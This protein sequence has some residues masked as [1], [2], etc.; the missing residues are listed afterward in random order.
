MFS[1]SDKRRTALR[2]SLLLIALV[3]SGCGGSEQH[4]EI[5]YGVVRD[6]VPTR[7]VVVQDD[8]KKARR[9]TGAKRGASPVLPKWSPDGNR[10]A[11][12]RFRRQG[13]PRSLQVYVVNGDG[14]NE[15]HV[16]EGTLPSWTADGRFL[17]VERLRLA[18]QVST[19]HVLAASG[20]GERKLTSGSS[21]VLSHDGKTVAFVRYTYAKQRGG[22][23]YRITAT[24]LYTIA[25]DGTKL[26]L[27]SKAEGKELT[28]PSWLPG[29][30]AIAVLERRGGGGLGGPL[31]RFSLNGKRR[32]VARGVGETYAWSPKGDLLAYTA[33]G[34]L[35]LI[36]PDG[37][38]VDAFGQSNAIDIEWSPDGTKV[39]FSMQEA[40]ET[41]QFVGFYIIDIEKGERRRFA[42]ADGFAAF[43]DWRPLRD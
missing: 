34:I 7:I 31:W 38:E 6:E 24:R 27:I 26:R 33:G 11:F 18:P 15:R 41:A 30:A 20:N 16:G 5:A 39:A 36:R 42:L 2:H 12:V 9:V 35:Y 21:P 28:Q 25:L 19:I 43:L 3:L 8:G 14:S 4:E 13:G 40:V 1:R 17:V 10:I 29:D 23:G 22:K 37:T 32:L